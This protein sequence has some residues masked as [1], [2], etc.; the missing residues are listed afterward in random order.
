MK[1]TREAQVSPE[2]KFRDGSVGSRIETENP[3]KYPD[4][5]ALE[6]KSPA[7]TD[8]KFQSNKIFDNSIHLDSPELVRRQ[9]NHSR[10]VRNGFAIQDNRTYPDND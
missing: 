10:D 3:K 4:V 7:M 1:Q 2:S 8:H 9:N 5:E 6:E